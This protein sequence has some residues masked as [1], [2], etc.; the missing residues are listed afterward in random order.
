MRF[1][2]ELQNDDKDECKNTNWMGLKNEHTHTNIYYIAK[3][4]EI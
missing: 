4:Y 2:V 1:S 3:L